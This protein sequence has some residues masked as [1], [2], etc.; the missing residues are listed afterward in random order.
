MVREFTDRAFQ[1]SALK[2]AKNEFQE[3]RRASSGYLYNYYTLLRTENGLQANILAKS[4]A[5]DKIDNSYER[6]IFGLKLTI[7]A[8][9]VIGLMAP[10][11]K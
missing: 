5:Q 2:K 4:I 8:S 6:R 10:F 1:I 3:A 11:I 7:A 9:I